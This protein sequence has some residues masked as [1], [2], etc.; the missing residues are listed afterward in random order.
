MK[1]CAPKFLLTQHEKMANMQG[2]STNL[3]F[4]IL[5]FLSVTLFV[6]LNT[7]PV[8]HVIIKTWFLRPPMLAPSLSLGVGTCDSSVGEIDVIVI[9]CRKFETCVSKKGSLMYATPDILFFK[10]GYSHELERG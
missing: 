10:G 2:I 5:V 9:E 3:G 4:W 6:V 8:G 7:I 1:V